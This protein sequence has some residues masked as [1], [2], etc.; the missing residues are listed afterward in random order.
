MAGRPNSCK[1]S[2]ESICPGAMCGR[3]RIARWTQIDA[4]ARAGV[5][6]RPVERRLGCKMNCRKVWDRALRAVRGRSAEFLKIIARADVPW[7]PVE[8]RLPCQMNCRKGECRACTAVCGRS[9]FFLQT[10]ARA[11]MPWSAVWRGSRRSMDTNR[12]HRASGCALEA[13]RKA[14]GVQG[15]LQ[16]S[17]RPGSEGRAR[18]VG[19]LP[20][21]HRASGCALERCLEGFEALDGHKSAPS[22][23]RR[24]PGGPW[25]GDCRAR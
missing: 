5:P 25:N 19:E 7:R 14:I 20:A 15:E 18:Q 1:P 11:D 3:V 21:N 10:I 2:R 13:G 16:E 24:C 6:W 8:W 9:V 4:I 17:M 12:C 23:E 22:R